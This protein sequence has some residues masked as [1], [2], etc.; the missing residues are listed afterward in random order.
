MYKHILESPARFQWDEDSK[1]CQSSNCRPTVAAS[2]ISYYKDKKIGITTARYMMT[3]SSRCT[4]TGVQQT[5]RALERYGINAAYKS[6]NHTEL[7]NLLLQNIPVDI[8]MVYAYLPWKYKQDKNFTG[9]H[10]VLAC[11]VAT[12][13][14]VRGIL[15][16]DPDRWGTGKIP[17]QFWPDSVVI[18][19]RN[20]AGN[21]AGYPLKPKFVPPTAVVGD[22]EMILKLKAED[23][24]PTLTNGQSNGVF[25]AEPNRKAPVVGRVGIGTKVRSVAEAYLPKEVDKHWRV[26][27]RDDKTLYMLRSDWSPVVPGGSPIVDQEFEDF[28]DL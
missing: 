17:Y 7:R 16:R 1:P 19:V 4:P 27:R 24:I 26:T 18:S 14:G 10:S 8:S 15:V 5:T 23:W 13:S 11:K 21:W 20:A 9:H 22:Y 3:S 28:I 6:L 2:I 12:Q 25:R